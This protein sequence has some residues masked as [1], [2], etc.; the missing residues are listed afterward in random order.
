M[1]LLDLWPEHLAP[2]SA[3]MAAQ[4]Q[5]AVGPGGVVGLRY[6]ALPMLL[7]CQGVPRAQWPQLMADLQVLERRAIE[8]FREKR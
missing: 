7:E 5:W 8:I 1:P 6:E 4:T 2:V 3:F